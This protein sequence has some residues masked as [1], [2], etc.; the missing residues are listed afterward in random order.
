[1]IFLQ[2]LWF[3]FFFLWVFG[4]HTDA[5]LSVWLYADCDQRI[6]KIVFQK[7][8][9]N[10]FWDVHKHSVKQLSNGFRIEVFHGDYWERVNLFECFI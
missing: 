7:Y 5:L 3:Q 6:S 9:W 2:V 1:M 4:H 10:I 8:I